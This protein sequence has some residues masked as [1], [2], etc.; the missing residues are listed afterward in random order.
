MTPR[1]ALGGFTLVE[2]LV[3]L[4]IVAF[5][6]S[7]VLAALGS[8]AD[9]T[10]RLRDK[11]LAQWIAFNQIS[12]TRLALQAPSTGTTTGTL[13]YAKARWAWSQ[14]IGELDIPG[15][16]RITVKVR[17]D[18][19]SGAPAADQPVDWLATALGF[20][21]NAVSAANGQLDWSPNPVVGGAAT[22]ETGATPS[23]GTTS[24]S[25]ENP[26]TGESDTSR[27]GGPGNDRPP[28][29]R[30]GGPGQGAGPPGAPPANPDT[31]G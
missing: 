5:G 20:R 29:G 3:A 17:R 16:L 1:R 22:E 15:I 21:G 27:D 30:T 19:G 18:D 26:G 11:S 4:M 10:E 13:D 2:V 8:A 14:E 7:A 25:G 12:T 6:M 9:T 31:G 28:G 23:S 24:G